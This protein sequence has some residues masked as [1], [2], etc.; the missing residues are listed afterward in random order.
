MTPAGVKHFS[1]AAHEQDLHMLSS[2]DKINISAMISFFFP[3]PFVFLFVH[4]PSN[5]SV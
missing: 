2:Y 4:V 3:V 5:M 1:Q